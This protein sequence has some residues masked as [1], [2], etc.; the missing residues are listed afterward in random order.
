MAVLLVITG[1]ILAARKDA[2]MLPTAASAHQRAGSGLIHPLDFVRL[3]S[4]KI[5]LRLGAAAGILPGDTEAIPDIKKLL[6]SI[7]R[8]NYPLPPIQR[9]LQP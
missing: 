7:E 5:R 3:R 2:G 6:L 8:P 1:S 4:T 9:G